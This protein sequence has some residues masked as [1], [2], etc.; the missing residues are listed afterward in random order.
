VENINV[1]DNFCRS[2]SIFAIAC[3]MTN[4]LKSIEMIR[5]TKCRDGVIAIIESVGD[6]NAIIILFREI[7][8]WMTN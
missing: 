1:C 6:K 5:Y 4:R 3:E 2:L 7:I 8:Y